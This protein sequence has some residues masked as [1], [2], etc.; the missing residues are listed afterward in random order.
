MLNAECGMIGE[1]WSRAD[2]PQYYKFSI[3]HFAFLIY[4]QSGTAL[5]IAHS[6]F[7]IQHFICSS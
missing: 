4:R 1:R 7:S 5:R 2:F 6:E 3:Q